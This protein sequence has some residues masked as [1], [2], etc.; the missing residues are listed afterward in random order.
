MYFIK[1]IYKISYEYPRRP[2]EPGDTGYIQHAEDKVLNNIINNYHNKILISEYIQQIYCH[3][4]L[5]IDTIKNDFIS[6][7]N[8]NT[9]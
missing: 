8:K 3:T 2:F 1:L 5:K 7:V 4:K 6:F 9:K